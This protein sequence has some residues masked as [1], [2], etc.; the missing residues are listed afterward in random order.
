[1]APS[2]PPII[3]KHQQPE[4]LTVAEAARQVGVSS[5]T[6][7]GWIT[8]GHLPVVRM[9]DRRRIRP[10]D[11]AAAHTRAHVGGVLPA[12]RQDRKHAGWRLRLLREAAG[13][14]QLEVAAASG[15]THE[16]ISQLELGRRA[17]HAPTVHAL[18]QALRI[19]PE[20]F[21]SDEPVG[22]TLLTVAEAAARL[23][24]P[25]DRVRNWLK[26]GVLAGGKVSGEWRVPTIAVAELERSGRLRGRSRRLDP[27]YRG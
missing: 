8:S 22:L 18:A 2:P 5:W 23:E 15:V 11:L 1:M 26:A 25:A 3:V 19:D 27:R 24:V 12:W 10:P 17:P 13:M 4:L 14:T 16:T 21:V 9:Y 6:I 7:K 20:Q